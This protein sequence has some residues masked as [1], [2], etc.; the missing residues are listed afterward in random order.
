MIFSQYHYISEKDFQYLLQTCS[1]IFGDSVNWSD[2]DLDFED[3]DTTKT[4]IYRNWDNP[5][6]LLPKATLMAYN[7][8]W[9]LKLS[10]LLLFVAV[11]VLL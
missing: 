6:E 11:A 3:F 9:Y 5:K 1:K 2:P 10:E 4:T 7:S 8:H